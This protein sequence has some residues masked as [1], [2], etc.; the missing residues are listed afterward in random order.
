V[1]P[2]PWAG[3]VPNF[4]ITNYTTMGYSYPALEYKDPIFEYTVNATKI[5][6]KHEF[7]FGFQFRSL[8]YRQNLPIGVTASPGVGRRPG[9]SMSS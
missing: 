7:Q 4:I 5:K 8:A 2:L 6:G 1:G 9:S 3:G